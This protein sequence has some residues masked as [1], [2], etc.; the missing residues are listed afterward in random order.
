MLFEL[1]NALFVERGKRLVENPQRRP[2]QIQTRQGHAALL[3]GRQGV[4]R[5]V[6]E[7]LEADS[8]QGLPDGVAGS[9]VMQGA[10]PAEV[11]F[12]R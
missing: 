7:T 12:R 6:F 2:G 1:G 3:A 5:H 9:R 8:G 11:F 10:E 4:A